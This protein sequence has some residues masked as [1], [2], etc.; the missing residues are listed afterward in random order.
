MIVAASSASSE[1]HELIIALAARN[2]LPTVYLSATLYCRRWI[3]LLRPE[4]PRRILPRSGPCQ[5]HPKGERPADLPVQAPTKYELGDQ[6]QTGEGA[7]A[8]NSRQRPRAPTRWSNNLGTAGSVES[9]MG[10]VAWGLWPTPR[11]PSPLISRVEDWRAGLGRSL[12]SPL[13]RPFVCE[14]PT[15]STMPRFPVTSTS[16]ATCGFPALRAPICFTPKLMGPI[17]LGR[18]SARASH[19]IGVEQP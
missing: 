4:L 8:Q 7:W 1:N 11:F 14:C 17:L 9:R 15:I 13:S 3:D 18:L 10:A 19:S 5:S 6:F 16:H 2:R 12:G